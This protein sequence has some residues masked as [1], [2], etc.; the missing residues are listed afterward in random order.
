MDGPGASEVSRVIEVR[1]IQDWLAP[2][3]L[4][5]FSG[6]ALFGLTAVW[7]V[8]THDGLTHIRRIE[9]LTA[10]L[11]EG[12]IF[13]RWF[14]DHLLGYGTPVF[15]YYSPGF[16]YPPALLHVAGLDLIL[17]I[18][19]A[20]SLGFGI[21]AWWMYRLSRQFVS[22]WPAMVAVVCFQ[23]FP[24][25]IYDLFIRGAFP[26]FSAFVWLPLVAFYTLKAANPDRSAADGSSHSIHLAVA[27][28]AWAGLIFTHNLTALMAVVL[29]GSLLA[30]FAAFQ[31]REPTRVLRVIA[32]SAAP[33]AI[34]IVL[35][36][37]YV[38][39]ALLE[40]GWVM[41]GRRLF[42]G[43]GMSHFLSWRELIDFNPL[44][45]YSF[46]SD[47]PRLPLYVIPVALA[48]MAAVLTVE[49]RKL[50]IFI[51]LTALLIHVLAWAM[52]D[53]SMWLWTRI[54]IFFDQVQFPWRWQ[55]FA[56]LGISLLLAASIEVLHRKGQTWTRV[57][58]LLSLLISL[59]LFAYA[60][61]GLNYTTSE[62]VPNE[63]HWS[64]S[65]DHLFWNL[66]VSIWAQHLMPVW[67]ATPM[68][69]ALKAGRKPWE[70]PPVPGPIDAAAVTPVKTSLLRQQ[71][72]VTTDQTFRL[73]FHKFYYPPW[74]VSIDGADVPVE[75]ATGLGL[76]AVTVPPGEHNVEIAWETTTAVWI[77]RLVTFA[78]WV[79]LFMLLFQAE[80][81]LGILVWKRGT[82][83]LEMRQF[84]F[85]VI[86]LAAGALMLLAA[87]GTTVRSWDF[88]AIGADYGS[89]RLEGI[90]AVPP[91]RAGDVAHVHLTWLVKGTGEPVKT[92]VHLVDEE[93]IGL[94]QHDMPPGGVNTPP[95]SWIPGRLLH[96]VHKI[97]LPDSLAPGSYRLVAGLYYP[98][99]VNDPIVPANGNDPRLEIG[100]VTV[101]P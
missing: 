20:L 21:S 55:I 62:D 101:L 41:N 1:K 64:D 43:I 46:P 18:R 23:F 9:A 90:R 65:V 94:S 72:M 30:A 58:P 85:P 77:G 76:A 6:L 59:Y 80:N 35:T 8:D 61:F 17:S 44:Y 22:A 57:T 69:D 81:G 96:S 68:V 2:L 86:W 88:T 33:V 87:S 25:R 7:P 82:G 42:A 12:V 11:R 52:T 73:L 13:P 54:E 34:G 78:G 32:G 71:Y 83:P 38:L 75:P 93:G 4:A 60:S 29:L 10:A 99:R 36:A 50:R 28:L 63:A 66:S 5:V 91:L 56:A 74:R 84:S 89:I 16:Y 45:S 24:Y 40:L 67:S 98:D 51:Q 31:R 53:T 14:P 19:I 70:V 79:V 100:S 37:W 47:R 92:F 15:N 49:L 3:L 97:K 39:P 95:Q 27:G 48:A 26:E